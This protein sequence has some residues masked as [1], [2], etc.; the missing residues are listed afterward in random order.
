MFLSELVTQAHTLVA[1]EDAEVVHIRAVASGHVAVGH[2]HL[3]F[4]HDTVV[5]LHLSGDADWTGIHITGQVGPNVSA[6]FGLVNELSANGKLLNCE[7]WSL[8]RDASLELAG[9]SIGGFRC[10]TDVRTRFTA[11]GARLNQAISVHG[12]Q[13]RHVDHHVEIHHDVAH[14]D[15]SLHLHA[16]CDDQSHAIAT[17]L[18]T[19]AENANHCDAGQV[20]K[21]LLLS[22]KARAEAIPE[23]EVLADEVLAAHGAASAPVDPNQLHYLMSRGLDEETAVALLIEGFMHDGFST[24]EHQT[25]VDEMRTRLTVHLECELKR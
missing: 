23:L 2:L 10:K 4:K 24:L 17:G 13:Q 21:N 22:E 12:T 14:T 19:I 20:F 1:A 25:L 16:A 6:A 8:G 18:L 7:D 15:S 11:A 9:L 3:D 5:V